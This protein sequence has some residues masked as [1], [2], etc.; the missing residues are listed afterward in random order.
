MQKQAEDSRNEQAYRQDE[1]PHLLAFV[2]APNPLRDYLVAKCLLHP[3]AT[4]RK[5]KPDAPQ[6]I[7]ASN[8]QFAARH[9][10]HFSSA[11]ERCFSVLKPSDPILNNQGL[12]ETGC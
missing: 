1:T 10:A 12:S 3:T 7:Q 8:T 2:T 5:C 9:E 6:E 4:M 11:N